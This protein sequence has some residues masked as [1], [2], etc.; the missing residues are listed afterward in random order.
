MVI[1]GAAICHW[2]HNNLM[3]RSAI[4][5]QMLTGCNGVNGGGMNH[6]VGQEKLA[7]VD[8]WGTIMAAKDWQGANRLQQAPIWHYINW[9]NGVMMAT[10]QN[11]TVFHPEVN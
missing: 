7:P 3:Y 9:I 2:F 4:M 6:Y 10:K 1:V 11:T 5:T 8:S